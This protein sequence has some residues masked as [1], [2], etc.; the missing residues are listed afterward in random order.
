MKYIV[1]LYAKLYELIHKYLNVNIPG[2]GFLYRFLKKD[3]Y[4][5]ING[6]KL[7]FNHKIY[8]L[9]SKGR[10]DLDFKNIWNLVALPQS[11]TFKYLNTLIDK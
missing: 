10:L 7:F 9:N 3:E 4:F 2:L 11:D 6:K 5:I 8:K 1:K